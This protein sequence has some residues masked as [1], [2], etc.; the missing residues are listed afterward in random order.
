MRQ[1]PNCQPV[2]PGPWTL[3]HD[4]AWPITCP[5][6]IALGWAREAVP[7]ASLPS[8]RPYAPCLAPGRPAYAERLCV[9]LHR[10]Q[11]RRPMRSF[12]AERL[13]MRSAGLHTCPE[14]THV[15]RVQGTGP[16]PG[17]EP[18]RARKPRDSRAGCR[19]QGAGCRAQGAGCRVQS[20]GMPTQAT[21][22]SSPRL[23]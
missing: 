4:G 15:P 23:P 17:H 13:C 8:A 1:K 10:G 6:P 3:V 11:L 18:T 16:T 14:A 20:A 2:A 22:L 21:R 12:Y 19:A 7:S 5:V 9:V